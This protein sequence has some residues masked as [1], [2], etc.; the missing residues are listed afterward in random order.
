MDCKKS[1]DEAQSSWKRDSERVVNDYL[2]VDAT[3]EYP[4]FFVLKL[5]LK[6]CMHLFSTQFLDKSHHAKGD[7]EDA[8]K[9]RVIKEGKKGRLKIQIY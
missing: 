3:L 4:D 1:A 5:Y 9:F 6:G 7:E 8:R 2:I